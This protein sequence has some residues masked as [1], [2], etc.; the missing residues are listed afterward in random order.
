[1][2]ATSSAVDPLPARTD[3]APVDSGEARAIAEADAWLTPSPSELAEMASR[4]EVRFL[5]PALS[6]DQPPTVGDAEATALSLSDR[7]RALLEQTLRALHAELRSFTERAF[8][9][10]APQPG[11]G[12]TP[13]FEEMLTDLQSRPENGYADGRRKLAREQAGLAPP[14]GEAHQPPGE[15]LIRLWSRLGDEME[16]RLA[17]DLGAERARQLRLSPQAGWMNRFSESGCAADL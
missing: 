3:D 17:D 7:E 2:Q 4:C 16:R 13:T 1:L 5:I 6:E 10:G 12:S 14:A 8:A 9:E 15:R 11:R